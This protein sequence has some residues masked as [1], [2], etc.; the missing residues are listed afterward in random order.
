MVRDRR[1]VTCTE[2]IDHYIV[3]QVNVDTPVATTA[4]DANAAVQREQMREGH[5]SSD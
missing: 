3:T 5:P 2:V 1:H 4:K